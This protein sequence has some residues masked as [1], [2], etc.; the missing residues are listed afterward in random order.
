M[1]FWFGSW[2]QGS[3]RMVQRNCRW[4]SV[5]VPLWAAWVQ[6]VVTRLSVEHALRYAGGLAFA[7]GH[8]AGEARNMH[9]LDG[10]RG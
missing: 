9:P 3:V 8:R 7:H 1:A 6:F 4:P 10:Q 5:T 2:V